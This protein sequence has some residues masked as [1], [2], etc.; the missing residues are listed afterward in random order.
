MKQ[1]DIL[2]GSGDRTVCSKYF[3]KTHTK[4]RPEYMKFLTGG[5]VPSLE[6]LCTK[7]INKKSVHLIFGLFCVGKL[8]SALIT[9]PLEPEHAKAKIKGERG[10]AYSTNILRECIKYTVLFYFLS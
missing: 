6:H 2:K 4:K 8:L 9:S 5:I 10:R 7:I 1:Q 3:K